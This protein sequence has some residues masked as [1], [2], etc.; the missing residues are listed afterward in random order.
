MRIYKYHI[1]Y[2]Q[3]EHNECAYRHSPLPRCRICTKQPGLQIHLLP[4][5]A[6]TLQS[7][8]NMTR[9]VILDR[10]TPFYH[11]RIAS[12]YNTTRSATTCL[13]RH[14]YHL[15]PPPHCSLCTARPGRSC[16]AGWRWFLFWTSL[17]DLWDLVFWSENIVNKMSSSQWSATK[18][19]NMQPQIIHQSWM[20]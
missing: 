8:Y 3:I 6:I 2:L 5:N 13:H 17:L 20:T 18:V 14:T 19:F 10:H 12:L 11:H 7:L 15:L 9:L 1:Q 4:F 16:I